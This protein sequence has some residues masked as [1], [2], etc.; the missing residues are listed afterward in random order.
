MMRQPVKSSRVLKGLLSLAAVCAVLFSMPVSSTGAFAAAVEPVVVERNPS[1]A[2]L[3]YA[4]G[5][6]LEGNDLISGTHTVG[7]VGSIAVTISGDSF[8]FMSTFGIDA[9]IV[10]GG[11]NANVYYYSPE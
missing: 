2:D 5:F 9:V 10:K 3:G 11:S 4:F 7:S 8:D 6:K 1:C